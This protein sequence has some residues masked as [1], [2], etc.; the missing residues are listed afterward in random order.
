M[1]K[2]FSLFLAVALLV[3]AMSLGALAE[4]T[5]VVYGTMQIPY[6][7]F[8]AAEGVASEVDAVSS[9]TNNK[10]KGGNLVAGS[11]SVAHEND[12][13]GDILG[14]IYP[15]AIVQAD[16]DALG[17][18]N[19]AFERM[20]EQPTAYKIVTVENGAASFSAVQGE[21]AAVNATATL[22]TSSVWGD[23]Q[24]DIDAINNADGTSDIGTIYGALVKT[25]D[26]SVYAMRHLENIWRD[27]ISWSS[28]FLTVEPHGCPLVSE[29]YADMPG[30]TISEIVYITESGYHTIATELYIPVKFDGGVAVADAS[31]TDGV[32]AVT[33]TNV[34]DDFVLA[35]AINGLE[36]EVTAERVTFANALP[37]SYTLVISDESGK[38]ADITASFVLSTD[39][40]PVA[41]DAESNTL[42]PADG[43]DASLAAAFIANLST[44][45]VGETSYAASGKGAVSIID[46]DGVVDLDAAQVMGRG[47]DAEQKLI[48]PESGEYT[49]TAASTGFEQ[50]ITFVVTVEK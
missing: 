6:A 12:A 15:V 11:Y 13:G 34:P 3:S 39:V 30:K 50:T 35:Y 17:E 46:V 44:V 4:G 10:W 2:W 42:V 40:M 36:A 47:A 25:S 19:F 28:G 45:T 9:A 43:A 26:G 22:S 41:F 14:V 33:L 48:F 7:A 49:L 20:D 27:E 16:L 38:Y 5:D 31:V 8:Y 23:Y 24:L 37:G 32:A 29:A 1:K 18:N 21:S